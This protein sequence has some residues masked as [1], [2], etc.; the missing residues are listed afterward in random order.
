[1]TKGETMNTI[2]M[3]N[4]GN[5]DVHLRD[6]ALLPENLRDKRY[7][8][9]RQLGEEI[10]ANYNRYVKAIELP[11]I[12]PCLR[13][14]LEDEGVPPDALY[15]HLFASDQQAPPVTPE[16]EWNKDTVF[17][18][19]VIERLLKSGGLAWTPPG[20][21][22][23]ARLQLTSRQVHVHTFPG[24]PANYNNMM[25][26][27]EQE[28]LRLTRWIDEEDA[29]YLEV[30]GGTPAMTSMLIVSGVEV[31][32]ERAHTLYVERG[33]D[34][35]YQIGIG[36]RF[37]ARRA[38]NTLR[39]QLALHGY[40]SARETLNRHGAV[41]VPDAERRQLVDRLLHYA[42]RRLAFDFDR[43]REALQR[44]QRYATGD[45]QAQ[46]QYR[47][48][49]LRPEEEQDRSPADLLAELIHS[50]RIKY[51][52]GDYAD[53]TQR[54][55]RFQEAILRHLVEQMGLEYSDNDGK[56][57]SGSWVKSVPGLTEFLEDY[58][59]GSGQKGI[60]LDRYLNRI[61]LM[62]IGEFFAEHDPEW[63]DVRSLLKRI[64]RI[65]DVARL[66]NKGLAGHGFEGV[67]QQDLERAFDDDS[68][69]IIPYLEGIYA[70]VFE[71]DVGPSPYE[72]I[73]EVIVGLLER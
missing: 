69:T 8:P 51:H 2:L 43:A 19:K 35:P 50:T 5:H 22:E 46:I 61:S 52:W 71:Q 10:L 37:F 40:K 36:R 73:N 3:A 41:I 66:R 45:V 25:E 29:V 14:L 65:S 32:G 21:H 70:A 9:S 7:V 27:F 24:S 60:D 53:F 68:D 13:W 54:L 33:A 38:R 23:K 34:R 28:L 47:L 58:T 62:A 26:Y 49:E 67:G 20:E 6:R 42:D 16:G 39:T 4:V 1:M 63:A 72:T 59:F 56:H 44:A 12:G 30:T 57:A 18:A 11:L 64:D 31:F 17:F 55:F 15:V 48:R